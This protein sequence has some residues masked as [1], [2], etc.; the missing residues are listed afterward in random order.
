MNASAQLAMFEPNADEATRLVDGYL[1]SA[2]RHA[3]L[4]DRFDLLQMPALAK[5]SERAMFHDVAQAETLASYVE[6][7]QLSGEA[8]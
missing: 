3:V 8:E 5:Q 2:E 4:A 6:L 1:K 7:L